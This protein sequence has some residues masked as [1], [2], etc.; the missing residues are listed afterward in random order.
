M[1]SEGKTVS[2]TNVQRFNGLCAVFT[3]NIIFEIGRKFFCSNTKSSLLSL[4]YGRPLRNKI[5]QIYFSIS[6]ESLIR[7]GRSFRTSDIYFCITASRSRRI[8]LS[9]SRYPV[10]RFA[11]LLWND[12]DPL[13]KIFPSLT[14]QSHLAVS[15][16][17]ATRKKFPKMTINL[18]GRLSYFFPFFSQTRL[19]CESPWRKIH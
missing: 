6:V 2:T 17:C 3:V 19:T 13:T 4:I 11:N 16:V 1:D 14:V 15:F 9:L 18:L 12:N 7:H 5:F 8:F 10:I